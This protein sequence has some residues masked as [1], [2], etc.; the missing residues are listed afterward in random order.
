MNSKTNTRG[1]QR[2]TLKS[3]PKDNEDTLQ[4]TSTTIMGDMIEIMRL[5][6]KGKRIKKERDNVYDY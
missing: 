3:N 6:E 1:R 4:S 2:S 5:V